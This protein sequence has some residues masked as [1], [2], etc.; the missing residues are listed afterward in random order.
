MTV[1]LVATELRLHFIQPLKKKFHT[2]Y[3]D[4][5]IYGS[6]LMAPLSDC[7]SSSFRER[8][9]LEKRKTLV[10]LAAHSI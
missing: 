5:K 10:K 8:A 1:N 3:M 4:V 6:E 7:D 2:K 9:R